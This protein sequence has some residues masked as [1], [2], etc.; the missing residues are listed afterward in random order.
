MWKCFKEGV[1]AGGPLRLDEIMTNSGGSAGE[2]WEDREPEN[3]G[4]VWLEIK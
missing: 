2:L 3:T 4:W 1:V